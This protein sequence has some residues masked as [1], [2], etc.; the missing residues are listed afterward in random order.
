MHYLGGENLKNTNIT[1][2]FDSVTLD[3]I[4]EQL[5]ESVEEYSDI[6]Y[7]IKRVVDFFR[8]WGL[9]SLADTIY[10]EY[11][12]LE[13]EHQKEVFELENVMAAMAVQFNNDLL[14]RLN[15]F[16]NNQ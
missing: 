12:G 16:R 14:H 4:Y 6:E 9:S 5:S 15:D 1:K 13:E 7:S 2:K 8:G 11:Y 10:T 3:S